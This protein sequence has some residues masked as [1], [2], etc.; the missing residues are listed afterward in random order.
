MPEIF[1]PGK[2]RLFLRAI[3][4]SDITTA[5]GKYIDSLFLNGPFDDFRPMSAYDFP[6]ECPSISDWNVWISFWSEYTMEHNALPRPLGKWQATTHRQH[7]WFYREDADILLHRVNGG[8]RVFGRRSTGSRTRSDQ[9]FELLGPAPATPD[10]SEYKP[11]SVRRITCELVSLGASGPTHVATEPIKYD[12]LSFLKSWGGEWMWDGI[13]LRGSFQDV[14]SAVKE[15]RARWVTD[16]SF[17]RKRA[18]SISS[19]GWIIFCPKTKSY[20]RGAFY[21]VSPDASAFRGE[22]LGLTALHLIALAL[23]THYGYDST[24]GSIHC[25]NERALGRAKLY[26]R[27]IPPGTKHGDLLRS[28][29]NTKNILKNVFT[30]HHIYGHADRTKRWDRMTLIEQLNCLCDAWAKGARHEGTISPRDASSQV[31]PRERAA[32]FINGIKQTGAL[33]EVARFELGLVEARRFY[34]TEL[35][36]HE[37]AFD[38]VDWLSLDFALS[39][40][41]KMYQIWLAKQASS[42]CGTR[43]MTARMLDNSDTCC[44]NCLLPDERASHLNQCLSPERTRQFRESIASLQVWLDRRHTH[45]DIAFWVPRYLLGRNRIQFQALPF[46]APPY[47]RMQL[48]P[49]MQ[50]LAEEQDSIGWS[51]FLEGKISKQFYHIQQAYLAGSPSPLN[52]RDWVKSFISELLTI[53][54]TQWLF[55]NITLHDK[56]Q[57]FLVATRKKELIAEIERLHNT[58]IDDIPPESKFLLDCDLDELRTADNDSQEQWIEA[59]LAARKAGLRLRRLNVRLH[60][61]S[62][63]GRRRV[64]PRPPPITF[65]RVTTQQ[66]VSHSVFADLLEPSPR[67]RP[68]EASLEAQLASNKRRKRRRKNED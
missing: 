39:K 44:P 7:D 20:L 51:H 25:D 38:R 6:E 57:G 50:R 45:P 32:V 36:W 37:D 52:G 67:T 34:V 23:K 8:T 63:R 54:H 58:P 61:Q 29:R 64:R 59:I 1:L 19:A 22:L 26:R 3:F 56:R 49:Q 66:P 17:D 30:Y 40:K 18:P 16:G 55:R 5:D 13:T 33:A 21:E 43:L 41:S 68:S 42:F 35:G 62:R 60:R 9:Q 53:S 65:E 15:G 2:D 10:L 11:C 4:L 24:M 28:L 47:L 14:L 48:S 31:L 27:R 46:Y 12:F